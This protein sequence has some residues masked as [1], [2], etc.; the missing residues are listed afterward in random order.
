MSVDVIARLYK[1]SVDCN[2]GDSVDQEDVIDLATRL[3]DGQIQ[4][5]NIATKCNWYCDQAIYNQYTD[6]HRLVFTSK[7]W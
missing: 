4:D 2:K 7:S 6:I 3:N 1:E 5:I